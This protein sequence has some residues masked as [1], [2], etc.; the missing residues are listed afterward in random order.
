MKS[1]WDLEKKQKKHRSSPK[2]QQNAGRKSMA[3]PGWPCRREAQYVG[4]FRLQI[5]RMRDAH[6]PWGEP[7]LADGDFYHGW[8]V[9]SITSQNIETFCS[10]RNLM[11]LV[12]LKQS[13]RIQQL[14]KLRI[15]RAVKSTWWP[16]RLPLRSCSAACATAVCF[17]CWSVTKIWWDVTLVKDVFKWCKIDYLHI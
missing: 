3:W 5:E 15:R 7:K 9:A 17:L 12:V 10:R 1:G 13:K 4:H 8:L 14:K 16:C 11:A 2:D 6:T